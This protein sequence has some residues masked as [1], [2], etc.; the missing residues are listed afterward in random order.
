MWCHSF[1][2]MRFLS[3]FRF[4]YFNCRYFMYSEYNI[5]YIIMWRSPRNV[6]NKTL[7]TR[8]IFYYDIQRKSYMKSC[9]GWLWQRSHPYI[10]QWISHNLLT[11]VMSR[12]LFTIKYHS[13]FLTKNILCFSVGNIYKNST[14]N[15]I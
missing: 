10:T 15:M 8:R 9:I 12:G 14:L 3:R 7:R 11:H 13:V 5:Q 6:T 4:L 1:D 2:H